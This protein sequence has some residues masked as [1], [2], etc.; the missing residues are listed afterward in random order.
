MAVSA[1]QRDI[2]LFLILQKNSPEQSGLFFIVKYDMEKC[3]SLQDN[4][5]AGI[6]YR[7][8]I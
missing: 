1:E 2:N 3:K 6:I 7:V 4:L 8:G 5:L